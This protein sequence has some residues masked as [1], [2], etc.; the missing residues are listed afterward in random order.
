MQGKIII[1]KVL[2]HLKIAF[3]IFISSNTKLKN[4]TIVIQIEW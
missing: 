4:K 1:E 3:K 2:N